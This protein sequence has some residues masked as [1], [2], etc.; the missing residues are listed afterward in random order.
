MTKKTDPEVNLHD[1]ISQ[2]SG[3]NIGRSQQIYEIFEPNLVQR[4]K[5]RQPS[6]KKCQI[7]LL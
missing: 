2:M 1:I 5:N 3:T 6:W 4:S 7:H